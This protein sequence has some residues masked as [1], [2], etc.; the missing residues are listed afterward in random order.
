MCTRLRSA[1]QRNGLKTKRDR[2]ILIL[3]SH[4]SKT[5]LW[6]R[7]LIMSLKK[8]FYFQSFKPIFIVL[9]EYFSNVLVIEIVYL[10]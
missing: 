9:D 7:Y 2:Q 5:N 8:S 3:L 1:F 6:F 4:E 10:S